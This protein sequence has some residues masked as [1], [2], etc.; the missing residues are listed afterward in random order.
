MQQ[1]IVACLKARQWKRFEVVTEAEAVSLVKCKYSKT[2][3]SNLWHRMTACVH[4]LKPEVQNALAFGLMVAGL[5]QGGHLS[6]ADYDQY[7]TPLPDNLHTTIP[8][9]VT[10]TCRCGR[11]P[12]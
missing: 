8:L 5:T 10:K 11:S 4:R 1:D 3:L 6:N 12:S 2:C 7:T 9:T